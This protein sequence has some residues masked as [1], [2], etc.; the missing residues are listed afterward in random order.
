MNNELDAE[1]PS[2]EELERL[3]RRAEYFRSLR[4]KRN[5]TTEELDKAIDEI[6]KEEAERDRMMEGGSAKS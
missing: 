4:P 1:R 5:L 3:K 6:I 2:P